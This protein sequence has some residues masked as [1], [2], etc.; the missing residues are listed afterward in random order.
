MYFIEILSIAWVIMIKK[1][2][3]TFQNFKGFDK[4]L[5]NIRKKCPS[6]DEDLKGFKA[7][8]T[9]DIKHNAYRV[10]TNTEKYSK[11]NKIH[12]KHYNAYVCKRFRCMESNKGAGQTP[13][14]LTFIY[15]AEESIIYFI[16]FY[17]K[18]NAEKEDFSKLKT[19]INILEKNYYY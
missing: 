13:F 7:A 18:G 9:V 12:S 6:L 2:E 14:R 19:A 10:P 5:R 15:N 11:V 8:L 3:F 17:F 16:Q 4:D 1:D